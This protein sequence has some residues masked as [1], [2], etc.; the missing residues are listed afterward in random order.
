M[1]EPELS[2]KSTTRSSVKKL[3]RPT[4]IFHRKNSDPS[5]TISYP[6]NFEKKEL[7][8]GDL[9]PHVSIKECPFDVT[10][11]GNLILRNKF[12]LKTPVKKKN[13]M[14]FMFERII[15]LTIE[16]EAN[17]YYYL[18]CI[19]IKDLSL[20]PSTKKT[21]L[22]LIDFNK[23]RVANRHVEYKLK[24]KDEETVRLWK[25]AIQK[26]LWNDLYEARDK[27]LKNLENR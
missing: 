20:P 2:R 16:E 21:V 12:K 14:A 27:C 7:T 23:N 11:Y 22:I 13:V 4:S 15:I 26:L 19:K 6:T 5:A 1:E 24:T 17:S 10:G 9:S 25:E 3:K 8:A 18:A